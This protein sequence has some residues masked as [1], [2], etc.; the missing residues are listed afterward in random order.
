MP[1]ALRK[2]RLTAR[3]SAMRISAWLKIRGETLPG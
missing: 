1:Q 3:V 2:V